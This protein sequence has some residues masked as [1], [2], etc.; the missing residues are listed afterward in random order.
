MKSQKTLKMIVLT[1]TALI[2]TSFGQWRIEELRPAPTDSTC[3]MAIADGRNE[4]KNH[5]YVSTSLGGIYEY[6]RSN[7]SWE[8]TTVTKGTK[9]A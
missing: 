9:L 1:T 6:T 3:F 8:I 2:S 5:L 7:S 4:W